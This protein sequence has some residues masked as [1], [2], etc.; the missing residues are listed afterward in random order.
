MIA[1]CYAENIMLEAGDPMEEQPVAYFSYL[2]R[3]WRTGEKSAWRAS[4]ED[5]QTGE[6]LGFGSL[7]ALWE[8]LQ[9][10]L[11]KFK[12]DNQKSGG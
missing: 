1:M 9:Q 6:R 8:F 4:L 2:L 10:Q 5:P 11:H 3:M 7:E 12:T